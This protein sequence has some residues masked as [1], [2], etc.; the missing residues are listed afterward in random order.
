M[1]KSFLNAILVMLPF[2]GAQTAGAIPIKYNIKFNLLSVNPNAG[3]PDGGSFFYDSTTHQFTNFFVQWSGNQFDFTTVANNPNINGT[4]SCLGGATGPQATFLALSDG[5]DSPDR[6]WSADVCPCFAMGIISG[7]G[8]GTLVI[9]AGGFGPPNTVTPSYYVGNPPFHFSYG[10]F[11][12]SPEPFGESVDQ[13]NDGFSPSLF[14]SIIY[15]GPIGQSF[16]PTFTSLNFVDLYT[17]DFGSPGGAQLLVR[18]RQ[19]SITGAIL[20]VSAPAGVT[21]GFSGETHFTFPVTIPLVPGNL[22][23]MEA[24]VASGGNWAVGSNG[25][26]DPY[27]GGSAIA[28]GA[29]Y[30]NDLYF[31]EGLAPAQ[32]I[33]VSD[34]SRVQQFTT[35]GNYLS[36][37]GINVGGR[38]MIGPAGMIIDPSGNFWLTD[39][40]NKNVAK[41]NS[42]GSFV[43]TYG[44]YG[45]GNG[46]FLNGIA[47]LVA[48]GNGNVW[49]VDSGNNRVQEFNNS[50]VFQNQFGS[51]GKGPGHFQGATAIAIDTA[52]FICVADVSRV[53]RF[54]TFGTY[55]GQFPI[56]V[57]GRFPL[58]PAGMTVDGNGDFWL[59]DI[60]N[61]TVSKFDSSGKYIGTY[62]SYGSGNGQFLNGIAG[63]ATDENGHVWI[64]DSGNSRV[65]GFNSDGVYQSQFG[66]AGKGNG[67]FQGAVAI[68]VAN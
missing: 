13:R 3:I 64:V 63:V 52:G 24:L 65:E 43:S 35:G 30:G 51:V 26:G 61:K 6:T 2:F 23:V 12:I 16:T 58:G 68:V 27:P 67:Q 46:Q 8:S 36:Q 45:S 37:F 57:G 28:L 44:S 40:F 59:T 49:V 33:Y 18:I 5:C 21:A 17:E 53:Q 25:G 60:A 38:F 9:N 7:S 31:R 50:G 42:S 19:G 15:L 55:V 66:S 41:F 47:G 29:Y 39:V 34:G 56:N 48:D 54:T 4:L 20:G 10:G 1:R 22:Y 32:H 62:G 14:Q 11:S